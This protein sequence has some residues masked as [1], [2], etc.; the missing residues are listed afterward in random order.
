[1]VATLYCVRDFE[2]VLGSDTALVFLNRLEWKLMWDQST[3]LR[4]L[5]PSNKLGHSGNCFFHPACPNPYLH[6][7]CCTT[8]LISTDMGVCTRWRVNFLAVSPKTQSLVWCTDMG[9][10]VQ[11]DMGFPHRLRLFSLYRIQC[12]SRPWSDPW[13]TFLRFP[14]FP[15]NA[16]T[17]V[18]LLFAYKGPLQSRESRVVSGWRDG[19]VGCDGGCILWFPQWETSYWKEYEYVRCS[20][21]Q[22]GW[23]LLIWSVIDYTVAALAAIGLFILGNWFLHARKHFQGPKIDFE[24][25]E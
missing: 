23:S 20:R 5:A 16:Q 17:P 9:F 8:D 2:E 13:T 19:W 11:L 24:D 21:F 7:H 15:P 10:A 12:Y 6:S 25:F 1:M 22:M 14:R 4:N 3:H 18:T